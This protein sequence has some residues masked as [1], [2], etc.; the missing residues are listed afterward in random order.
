[1]NDII[2]YET[3]E[4]F[5]EARVD[6]LAVAV[7]DLPAL[8]DF[9]WRV[10]RA[11]AHL[12]KRDATSAI[13]NINREIERLTEIRNRMQSVVEARRSYLLEKVRA[14]MEAHAVDKLQLPGVGVFR[15]RKLPPS[16]EEDSELTFDSLS[17]EDKRRV[18]E[19]HPDHFGI[20]EVYKPDKRAILASLK[21]GKEVPF[22]HLRDS[23]A[24]FEFK[25][26]E[27]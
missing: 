20:T 14:A 17:P 5:D 10:G 15:Y 22:F 4:I 18:C 8:Q 7:A 25:S 11:I 24:K 1:M 12:D 3:G 26:E 2:D 13:A 23:I 27:K 21:E 6:A 9:S 19:G 16:V